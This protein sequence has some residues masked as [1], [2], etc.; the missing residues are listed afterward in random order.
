VTAG[1]IAGLTLISCVVTIL[2]AGQ[3]GAAPLGSASN[4]SKV[5]AVGAATSVG[6]LLLG[7]TISAGEDRYRTVVQTYLAQPR[8]GQ[9]LVAKL[10]TGAVVGAALGAAAF[11]FDLAFAVPLFAVKGV[12]HL[13]INVAEIGAGTVLATACF[14]LLGVSIGALTRNTV[15]SI[16][17][18]LVWVGI[19]ELAILQP[20]FPTVGEWLP[21]AA[22][23]ALT[24]LG[25]NDPGLL[26]PAVAAV[27]LAGWGVALSL[28]ASQV[29]VRRE[30]R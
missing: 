7:I 21:A 19:I 28:I 16:V 24:N 18:A 14:G 1:V 6:M 11:L 30:V 9:V 2:L 10:V 22:S 23:K 27:V 17:A 29:T 15:V 5:L 26:N 8:R 20:A 4:V 3:N 13:P 25:Q 12:H